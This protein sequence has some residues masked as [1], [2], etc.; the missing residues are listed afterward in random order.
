LL[1]SILNELETDSARRAPKLGHATTSLPPG[2]G[3]L[4]FSHTHLTSVEPD[5]ALRLRILDGLAFRG[6][7][8]L[9]L[10]DVLSF[11]DHC[12][13]TTLTTSA[14]RWQMTLHRALPKRLHIMKN[15]PPSVK[16]SWTAKWTRPKCARK[17]NKPVRSR[18]PRDPPRTNNAGLRESFDGI[19][20]REMDIRLS[21]YPAA[22]KTPGEFCRRRSSSGSMNHGGDEAAR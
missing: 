22:S 2:A 19:E 15:S 17:L 14:F 12:T 1:N 13:I 5:R 9:A 16:V 20:R 21:D 11:L 10:L 3:L 4:R 7:R 18:N 8:P 6:S